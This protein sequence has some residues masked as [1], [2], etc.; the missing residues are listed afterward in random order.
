MSKQ[1]QF[2]EDLITLSSELKS[3]ED[4]LKK[5]IKKY[6][7]KNKNLIQDKWKHI[8]LNSQQICLNKSPK[9]SLQQFNKFASALEQE[10]Q[11]EQNDKILQ[12]QNRIF[13][14]KEDIAGNNYERGLILSHYLAIISENPSYL[15]ISLASNLWSQ[16]LSLDSQDIPDQ[17]TAGQMW[18]KCYETL[19]LS[20]D[21]LNSYNNQ[22]KHKFQKETIKY[23][24]KFHKNLKDVQSDDFLIG[25]FNVIIQSIDCKKFTKH[26][27]EGSISKLI[28]EFTIR[29]FTNEQSIDNIKSNISTPDIPTTEEEFKLQYISNHLNLLSSGTSNPSNLSK[30]MISLPNFNQDLFDESGNFLIKFWSKNLDKIADK[31]F[32]IFVKQIYT[33][34]EDFRLF[35]RYLC[36]YHNETDR[37]LKTNK[38]TKADLYDYFRK[39]CL[40]KNWLH[41]I[42][43]EQKICLLPDQTFIYKKPIIKALMNQFLIKLEEK[44]KNPSKIQGD[45]L[46]EYLFDSSILEKNS[47]KP[48]S[49]FKAVSIFNPTEKQKEPQQIEMWVNCVSINQFLYQLKYK[50]IYKQVLLD[51]LDRFG[52]SINQ[53]KL[54]KHLEGTYKYQKNEETDGFC[55]KLTE[56]QQQEIRNKNYTCYDKVYF[57]RFYYCYKSWD[58]TYYYDEETF[59][60]D[61]NQIL[62]IY[63]TVREKKRSIL[64]WNGRSDSGFD[65]EKFKKLQGIFLANEE[66][67][68]LLR[69]Q[70]SYW[71]CKKEQSIQNKKK[72]EERIEEVVLYYIKICLD[73]FKDQNT[74]KKGYVNCINL[75]KL[76]K[77]ARLEYYKNDADKLDKIQKSTIMSVNSVIESNI[78]GISAIRHET[79]GLQKGHSSANK[80]FNLDSSSLNMG[81]SHLSQNSLNQNDMFIGIGFNTDSVIIEDFDESKIIGIS[82]GSIIDEDYI[83]SDI[84]GLAK[85]SGS[86]LPLPIML[87]V[88]SIENPNLE[89]TNSVIIDPTGYSTSD[90]F[91]I[92][93]NVT[94][95]Y[96]NPLGLINTD[97]NSINAI[98]KISSIASHNFTIRTA[99]EFNSMNDIKNPESGFDCNFYFLKLFEEISLQKKSKRENYAEL[100]LKQSVSLKN[101]QDFN[102]KFIHDYDLLKNEYDKQIYYLM[103]NEIDLSKEINQID[104]ESYK[105]YIGSKDCDN[106]SLQ[107]SLSGLQDEVQELFDKMNQTFQ[108]YINGC[109]FVPENTKFVEYAIKE[110]LYGHLYLNLKKFQPTAL[111]IECYQYR[112]G[113]NQQDNLHRKEIE[114]IKSLGDKDKSRKSQAI[115]AQKKGKELRSSQF[116]QYELIELLN[117]LEKDSFQWSHQFNITQ[118][119]ENFG[120]WKNRFNDLYSEL[121]FYEKL[122]ELK[123]H[124]Y[125]KIYGNFGADCE[126]PCVSYMAFISKEDY[127]FSEIRILN[128][129]KKLFDKEGWS[130]ILNLIETANT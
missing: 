10:L 60:R 93:D 66:F 3:Y 14:P 27:L 96:Y 42:L 107:S 103:F 79:S 123:D 37:L 95:K 67:I 69:E 73:R 20:I 122:D 112:H 38:Q 75:L 48:V 49:K 127:L 74:N 52:K 120:I 47:N 21:L 101:S 41:P 71:Q 90:Q 105:I 87:R 108:K 19:F 121:K 88:E 118:K 102:Q 91:N 12:K 15:G 82:S 110:Y 56:S 54:Y 98:P 130:Y 85:N 76:L 80:N 2:F 36:Y 34:P 35:F 106:K 65:P 51:N 1:T 46:Y 94:S 6:R 68:G 78:K 62:D 63:E 124:D 11:V 111:D 43:C 57:K 32:D 89:K 7:I 129:F 26:W 117:K 115:E 53:D 30:K 114:L 4:I 64:V 39:T 8:I 9:L 24:T 84:F 13:K 50:D 128:I 104:L 18:Q 126:W 97:S 40:I 109:C 33:L 22:K 55:S 113:P 116:W 83:H 29:N 25:I 5:K 17:L 58:D 45:I 44:F 119:F 28:N 77:K 70:I 125:A 59:V 81:K 92:V 99:N 31:L 86:E 72:S 100:G 23:R 61:L 16:N